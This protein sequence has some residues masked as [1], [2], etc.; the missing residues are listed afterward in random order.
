MEAAIKA[1]RECFMQEV[2]RAARGPGIDSEKDVDAIL[3]A[4]SF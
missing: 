4:C 3:E 2:Y 1:S